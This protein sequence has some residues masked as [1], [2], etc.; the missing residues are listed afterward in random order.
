MDEFK[1]AVITPTT[2]ICRMGY[3][4]SL[5]KL[6]MYFSQ[7]RV[8]E[9]IENQWLTVDS[10]EGSGIAG[11]YHSM[12]KKYL[13]DT[14]TRW[15]HFLSVEDDMGFEPDVLH[16]LARRKLPIVGCTY[17]TNKGWP[18]RFTAIAKSKVD[19]IDTDES[20]HGVEEAYVIPQGMTLVAREVFERTP[21]PWFMQGY[22]EETDT[23]GFA[24]DYY[25]CL[26]AAKVGYTPWIDHDASKRIWHI[27]VKNYRWD[28]SDEN[29]HC[30][31]K[32]LEEAENGNIA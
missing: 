23:Y 12:I 17:K 18:V 25:F 21:K 30:P 16:I 9:D 27:G 13:N 28:V 29:T 2:G 6:V 14:K 5:A 8:F 24:Q 4:Q 15:T 20:K 11:N 31:R 19:T 22:N 7:V 1:V 10:I 26:Q 3:A 32:A